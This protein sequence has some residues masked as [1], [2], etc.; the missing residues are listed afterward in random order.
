M[1]I[2]TPLNGHFRHKLF[3][4]II[5]LFLRLSY[6]EDEA[7]VRPVRVEIYNNQRNYQQKSPSINESVGTSS[8]SEFGEVR[9][10]PISMR[11]SVA[12][13]QLMIRSPPQPPTRQQQKHYMSSPVSMNPNAYKNNAAGGNRPSRPP[14]TPREVEA[15]L[16]YSPTNLLNNR[17]SVNLINLNI[18]R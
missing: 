15:P 10:P 11:P 14:P 5:H 13:R 12:P 2:T 18:Q 7:T 16:S 1:S 4:F 6:R 17:F 8:S 3:H 9:P